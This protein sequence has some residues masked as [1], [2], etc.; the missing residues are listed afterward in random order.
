MA[1]KTKTRQEKAFN[2]LRA[3]IL[4]GR[5]TPGQKLPFAEL[6]A[7]YSVSV[8]VI[9]EALSRLAEQGLVQVEP[10]LGFRV[11]SISEADLVHL[12][13]ARREIETLTLR[14]ALAEGGVA[15]ES[16]VL[17]AHYRLGRC[18]QR[19]PEDPDRLN[20]DWVEAHAVFHQTLLDG[21]ENPRL[22]AI[23]LQLR[24]AA[25]L[26]RRWSV[27]LGHRP[28][29]DI[30]GEHQALVDAVTE[31]NA[32]EAVRVL[33]RHIA[34]TTELLLDSGLIEPSDGRRGS[35]AS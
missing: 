6:C 18:P 15:W 22:K 9:R 2:A 24:D 11:T 29:R 21:C 30:A 5:L 27:P 20:D 26:Y 17:A 33:D 19:D 10:Q 4:A 7:D 25:E 1:P 35:V 13:E 12:T 3:D 8:G 23:A 31:R 28:G 16:E 14:H 34:L 32:D